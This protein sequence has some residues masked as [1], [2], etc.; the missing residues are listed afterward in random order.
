MNKN[1]PLSQVL[2][3]RIPEIVSR[4]IACVKKNVTAAKINEM[5][6]HAIREA[7][8]E[9]EQTIKEKNKEIFDVLNSTSDGFFSLDHDYTIT[10]VNRS[11]LEITQL[12]E[13]AQLGKNL[14]DVLPG[15]RNP[16]LGYWK[17]YNEAM[18]KR[19]AV[20]FVEY[21][22]ELDVWTAVNVYPK[23]DG[24]LAVDLIPRMLMTSLV[25]P[26]FLIFVQETLGQGL[27]QR[28]GFIRFLVAVLTGWR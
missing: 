9:F 24:G 10:Q 4:W 3:A 23:S 13:E 20:S 22:Q 14:Y 8:V 19:K 6:D 25:F 27:K 28:D 5:V 16:E 12:P 18:E 15:A 7:A 11:H 17:S 26:T 2:E 1:L 21:Y